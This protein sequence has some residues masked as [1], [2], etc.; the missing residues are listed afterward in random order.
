MGAEGSKGATG[1][2][3]PQG[4]QGY[5]GPRG[6]TGQRG[7]EGRQGVSGENAEICAMTCQEQVA[8]IMMTK[9]TFRD[10]LFAK[11]TSANALSSICVGQTCLSDE[12]VTALQTLAKRNVI[13]EQLCI[14]DKCLSKA[15]LGSILA[16]RE[17]KRV[18]AGDKCFSESDVQRVLKFEAK[19]NAKIASIETVLA[20]KLAK[21]TVIDVSGIVSTGN[22]KV[23]GDCCGRSTTLSGHNLVV[24]SGYVNE[25]IDLNYMRN[26]LLP[27]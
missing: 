6:E 3:G 19:M 13:A 16:D 21:N 24:E 4:I 10:A 2:E 14:D 11:V 20:D 15:E 17:A 22:I 1:L 23:I 12:D 7:T 5:K 27:Q 26:A 18:C 9:P 25:T 8:D